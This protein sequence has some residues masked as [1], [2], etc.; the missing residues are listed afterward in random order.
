M[1]I[2]RKKTAC[3]FT[4]LTG[5]AALFAADPEKTLQDPYG[6][7]SHIS[8]RAP[9]NVL[10]E[11]ARM[12]EADI[13]WVRTDFT[14]E[15]IEKNRDSGIFP[16]LTE[17]S[18]RQKS[19]RSTFFRFST[20]TYLGRVQPGSTPMHG[21]NTSAARSA[22]TRRICASGKYGT[23]RTETISGGIPQAE[24]TMLPC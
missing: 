12:Q 4:A 14:W 8:H 13:N 3:F 19:K 16:I 20:M 5:M 22:A 7:C 24:K 1:I 9:A 17:Q 21:T 18:N 23:N 6:V 2:N 15:R 10:P 11:L